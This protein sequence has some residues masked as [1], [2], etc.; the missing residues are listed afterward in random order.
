MATQLN[1]TPTD[2]FIVRIMELISIASSHRQQSIDH[3]LRLASA[4][5]AS[6]L[7]VRPK[8]VFSA[9]GNKQLRLTQV[10]CKKQVYGSLLSKICTQA[11]T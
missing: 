9:Q 2:Y 3:D 11:R 5:A 6:S 8:R 4:K 7:R 10:Q 1:S